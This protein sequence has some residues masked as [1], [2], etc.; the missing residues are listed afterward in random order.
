VSFGL[1]GGAS[2][3]MSEDDLALDDRA[4]VEPQLSL[5]DVVQ[6]RSQKRRRLDRRSRIIATP[7]YG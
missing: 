7:V 3:V 5:V 6:C 1:L 2:I 4:L